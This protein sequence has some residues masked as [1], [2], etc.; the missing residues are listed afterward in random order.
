ME[1]VL[2]GRDVPVSVEPRL[3]E[4]AYGVY[5]GT[6]W[7]EGY[8]LKR[9]IIPCRHEGGESY[10]DIAHRV[11][12]FLDEIKEEA[13]KGNVLLVCHGAVS[14]VIATYFRDDLD[15]DEFIDGII[16]NGGFRVYEYPKRNVEFIKKIQQ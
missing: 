14:R 1:T 6:P 15:N 5:E 10:F 16:P 11:Y 7:L 3:I 2:E 9:R 8:H 4:M 13:E 12:P